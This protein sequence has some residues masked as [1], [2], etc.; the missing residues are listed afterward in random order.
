MRPIYRIYYDPELYN[1]INLCDH[2]T[3]ITRMKRVEEAG[4][5]LVGFV[6]DIPEMLRPTLI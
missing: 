6:V 1:L 2:L 5:A 4:I 3:K